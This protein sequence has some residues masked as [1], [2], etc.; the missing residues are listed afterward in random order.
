[1]KLSAA[2]PVVCAVSLGLIAAGGGTIA[3]PAALAPIHPQAVAARSP[4]IHRPPARSAQA[5]SQPPSVAHTPRTPNRY[6]TPYKSRVR[7]SLAM[8]DAPIRPGVKGL[9]GC[10]G[11]YIGWRDQLAA[12]M[13]QSN[14]YTPWPDDKIRFDQIERAFAAGAL[15]D[16]KLVLTLEPVFKESDFPPDVRGAFRAGLAASQAVFAQSD[17]QH[18][19][20]LVIGQPDLSPRER[21]AQ[22]EANADQAF[23]P[24]AAPCERITGG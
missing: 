4:S 12:L 9:A 13:L 18:T 11:R 3:V 20:V 10:Y 14:S 19:Q 5:G 2:A 6:K 1:M 21:M 8:T 23:A 16:R 17:Y 15:Q 24:L 22:L 7:R